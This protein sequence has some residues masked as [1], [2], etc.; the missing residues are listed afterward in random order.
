MSYF[1]SKFKL[2]LV[3]GNFLFYLIPIGYWF[4]EVTFLWQFE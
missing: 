2:D 3:F 1:K 4:A